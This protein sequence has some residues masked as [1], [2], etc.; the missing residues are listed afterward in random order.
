MLHRL[1]FRSEALLADEPV[2][3]VVRVVECP[4]PVRFATALDR[5]V[6][7]H[8]WVRLARWHNSL[9]YVC[10]S[11]FL[12]SA[13]RVTQ[14]RTA[15]DARWFV[16]WCGESCSC[17]VGLDRALI[18]SGTLSVIGMCGIEKYSVLVRYGALF[19]VLACSPAFVYLRDT[20]CGLTEQ[21][22]S[23]DGNAAD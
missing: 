1:Q 20:P 9:Q 23:C 2:L 15:L 10:E 13:I 14:L 16:E 7:A 4:Q 21:S 17:T 5:E 8:L 11:T 12:L 22:G 19:F 3:K 18:D 6:T